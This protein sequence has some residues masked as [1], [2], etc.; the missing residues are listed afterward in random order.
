MSNYMTATKFFQYAADK[1]AAGK[2][3]SKTKQKRGGE[4]EEESKAQTLM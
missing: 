3:K 1:T 2:S 4:A